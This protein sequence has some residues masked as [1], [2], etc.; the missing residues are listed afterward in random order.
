V[1][2]ERDLDGDGRASVLVVSEDAGSGSSTTRVDLLRPGRSTPLRVEAETSFDRFLTL[3]PVPAELRGEGAARVREA[4]EDALFPSTCEGP[5]ASL[6]WLLRWESVVP[7]AGS[8][9]PRAR[10]PLSW[11]PGRPVL[12]GSYAIRTTSPGLARPPASRDGTSSSAAADPA[13]VWVGYLGVNHRRAE[14]GSLTAEPRLLARQDGRELLGTAHG[15]VLAEVAA[16]RHAWIYVTPGGQRLR[17][18]TIRSARLVG[19]VAIIEARLEQIGETLHVRVDLATGET[20]VGAPVQGSEAP[21]EGVVEGALTV[22]MESFGGGVPSLVNTRKAIRV[23]IS[24]DGQRFESDEPNGT[25]VS[26][27]RSTAAGRPGSCFLIP[28]QKVCLALDDGSATS[29]SW[30]IE[31]IGRAQVAG[32]TCEEVRAEAFRGPRVDLC[33]TR[34]L[35]PGGLWLLEVLQLPGGTRS[36]REALAR[37]GVGDFPLQA[38]TWQGRPGLEMTVLGVKPSRV[39]GSRIAVPPGF[40]V[41]P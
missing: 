12:P 2:V 29:P 34:E 41:R 23:S 20:E 19:E 24:A 6:Q 8:E 9:R 4:V 14:D 25:Y 28:S 33:V 26:L 21:F 11:N 37:A 40:E 15:V 5:E 30:K 27:Q 7:R 35:G 31:R 1:Q 10:L 38:A 3:V 17:H 13:E 18:P 32:I 22:T 36:L 16:D 39:D